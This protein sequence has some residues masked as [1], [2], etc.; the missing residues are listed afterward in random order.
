MRKLQGFF[1]FGVNSGVN[2]YFTNNFLSLF[3]NA[4]LPPSSLSNF[5]VESDCDTRKLMVHGWLSFL[6]M[7]SCVVSHS[8]YNKFSSQ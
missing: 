8:K 2:V 3:S 4:S 5:Y 6:K 1:V 7:T